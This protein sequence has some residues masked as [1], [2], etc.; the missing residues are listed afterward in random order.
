METDLQ[1]AAIMGGLS[2]R[3]GQRVDLPLLLDRWSQFV[4]EVQEGRRAT[5]E[6][7]AD[8][9]AIRDLLA[10]VITGVGAARGQEIAEAVRP[11]DE[12]FR[13]ATR[14]VDHPQRSI[15]SDRWWWSRKPTGFGNFTQTT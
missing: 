8:E 3:T 5:D 6:E 2:V 1:L 15:R 9:L 10:E 4:R 14:I 12:A 11:A 13:L 7:F